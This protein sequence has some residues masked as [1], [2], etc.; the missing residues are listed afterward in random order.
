MTPGQVAYEAYCR[1][2][3]WKSLVT[4]Q[5]L[6]TWANLSSRIRAAWEVAATAVQQ[7]Q[8]VGLTEAARK[9]FEGIQHGTT[10]DNS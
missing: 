5:R 2:C 1:H 10:P 9:G 7:Y 8:T 3:D 6:P 4:D